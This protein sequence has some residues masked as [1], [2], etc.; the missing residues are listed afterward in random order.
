MLFG[1]ITA[2]LITTASATSAGTALQ[3]GQIDMYVVQHG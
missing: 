2:G 1:H 3:R